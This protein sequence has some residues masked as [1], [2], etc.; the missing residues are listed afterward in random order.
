[1]DDIFVVQD[2]IKLVLATETQVKLTE[3]EQA[4]LR[5]SDNQQ[6][7]GLDLLSPGMSH[8][9]Q[10]GTQ[11]NGPCAP[12]LGKGAG[13]GPDSASRCSFRMVGRPRNRNCES[14]VT[15][16]KHWKSILPIRCWCR[17]CAGLDIG[18]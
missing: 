6:C 5:Y 2:E 11:K 15:L 16:T 4:R 7:R 1:M 9:R 17:P 8:Y 12:L 14:A 18:W 10:A 3:G 13:A